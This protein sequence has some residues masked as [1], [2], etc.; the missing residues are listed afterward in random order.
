M[1]Q[2]NQQLEHN[3]QLLKTKYLNTYND[4]L[5]GQEAVSKDRERSQALEIKNKRLES[6]LG[7]VLRRLQLFED[8]QGI[9][10]LGDQQLNSFEQLLF[11]SLDKLKSE[12]AK[13]IYRDEINTLKQK[14]K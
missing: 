1:K 2:K 7:S 5:Q 3:L 12:K 4:F 14:L 9:A 10:L 6:L 8:Q 13:R 11:S